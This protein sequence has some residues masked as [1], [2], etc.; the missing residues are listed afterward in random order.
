MKDNIMFVV[1]TLVG[2]GAEKTVANLSRY[3]SNEYNIFIVVLRDTEKKYSYN[4]NLIVLSKEQPQ[5]IFLKCIYYLKQIRVLKKLKKEHNIKTTIS[6]LVQAD[7]IN[8]LSKGKDKTIISIRNKDSKLWKNRIIQKLIRYTLKKCDIVVS[9]SKQVKDDI[10]DNFNIAENKIITIYNPCLISE[11]DTDTKEIDKNIF[12]VGKTFINMGRLTE[13]KGQWHLIRAFK[14]VVEKEEDAKLLIL[15]EGPLEEYL[16]KMIISLNL[17]NSIKLLGFVTNPYDYLRKSD[18]FI[19]PSL[20]EGLGNS[21]LEA[22]AC[23]LPVISSDCE[24]GPREILSPSSDYRQKIKDKYELGEYGILIPV[25]DSIMYDAN[26]ILTKEEEILSDSMIDI[27]TDNVLM[28][29]YK[30]KSLDRIND[31]SIDIIKKEWENI[32]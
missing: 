9:I 20:Y 31:F 2:G 30:Q 12:S 32:L 8:V 14:R 22:M 23:S 4:G 15:G 16:Q 5:N 7:L 17:E 18:V 28:Q 24:C 3:L 25:C 21:I 10:I 27:I 11:F 6:F 1:P 26:A 29:K 13:Q 19:F